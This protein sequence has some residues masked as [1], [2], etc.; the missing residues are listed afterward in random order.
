MKHSMLSE[1]VNQKDIL[2]QPYI[3]N[4]DDMV[5]YHG[6]SQIS[7]PT[8]LEF[9]FR[10]K[11]M[12]TIDELHHD[13][14]DLSTEKFGIPVRNLLF[15][16]PNDS[17][18]VMM[19][20]H[21]N[22]IVPIGTKYRIF[23]HPR[24]HDMTEDLVVGQHSDIPIK[25]IT[26]ELMQLDDGSMGEYYKHYVDWLQEHEELTSGD[27]SAIIGA[28][29]N[30]EDNADDDNELVHVH[31]KNF[32]KKHKSD[33]LEVIM[34][35]MQESIESI[36]QQYVNELEELGKDENIDGVELMVYA[37]DGFYIIP[38]EQFFN[39]I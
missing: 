34:N 15:T 1:G 6:T 39:M 19:Y 23:Y 5:L 36:S 24:I 11:P 29:Y 33:I 14:N 28:F 3:S 10:T 4:H 17:D 25:N 31:L 13:I 38:E 32:I 30:L 20:G 37:P 12:S 35:A 21:S 18:Q 16:Y 9:R 8:K 7:K 26:D 27:Y 2:D 22:V